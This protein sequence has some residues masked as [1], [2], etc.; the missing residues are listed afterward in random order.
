[1][2]KGKQVILSGERRQKIER[3]EIL[4]RIRVQIKIL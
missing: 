3:D 1:M 2:L 4:Q